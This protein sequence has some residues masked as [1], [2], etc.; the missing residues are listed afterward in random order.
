MYDEL[1]RTDDRASTEGV[2]EPLDP[3]AERGTRDGF[4]SGLADVLLSIPAGVG[5]RIGG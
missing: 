4:W 5:I 2:G 1:R 3:E